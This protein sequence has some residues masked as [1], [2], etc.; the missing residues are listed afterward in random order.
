MAVADLTENGTLM[1]AEKLSDSMHIRPEKKSISF[2]NVP[3]KIFVSSGTTLRTSE[4]YCL[5]R[6]PV[7]E[8]K[9]LFFSGLL[10]RLTVSE[11]AYKCNKYL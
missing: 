9:R 4:T 6:K 5:L 2:C 3:E 8:M 11:Y 1:G 10:C 7:M